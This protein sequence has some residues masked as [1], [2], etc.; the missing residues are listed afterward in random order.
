MS[1]P[2]TTVEDIVSV[3]FLLLDHLGIDK[4]HA[5][6]GSSLGGMQAILGAAMFPERVG[7]YV[8]SCYT[9]E[10]IKQNYNVIK[11]DVYEK[12]S[13]TQCFKFNQP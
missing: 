5:C 2:V 4:V 3:Q 9:R 11:I 1:F 10:C 12:Y 7:R 8:S 6:V 13:V